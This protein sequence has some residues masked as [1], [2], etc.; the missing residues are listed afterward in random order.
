MAKKNISK[1]GMVIFIEGETDEYF[2]K[3]L[4]NYFRNIPQ[5]VCAVEK[6]IL[7][8]LKGVGNF[9]SK[10]LNKFRVNC[11]K[12]YPELTFVV[13][14]AYDT[15]VFEYATKPAVNWKRV[16]GELKKDGAVKVVHLKAVRNIEDWFVLDMKGVC[17][18]LGIR[19]SAINAKTGLE[20]MKKVFKTKN[21]IY[22]KGSYTEK[23]IPFLD[24]HLIYQALQTTLEPLKRVYLK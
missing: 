14:C 7:I 1:I 24:M 4:L 16:E 23:F 17:N 21:R 5:K 3:E 12:K 13:F 11:V 10:A 2:Y 22:Q 19:E 8:N 15:D 6:Y 9:N 20:K 18:Y